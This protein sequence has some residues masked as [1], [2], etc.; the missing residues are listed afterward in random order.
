MPT[1]DELVSLTSVFGS[2]NSIEEQELRTKK[3]PE[4]EDT[5]AEKTPAADSAA[6]TELPANAAVQRTPSTAEPLPLPTI[7]EEDSLFNIYAIPL[8]YPAAYALVKPYVRGFDMNG[9]D[10]PS[11]KDVT[12]DN[13]WQLKGQS[14]ESN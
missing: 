6:K 7:S 8:Y 1:T 5:N 2:L 10:A 11:L 12:I 14:P 13:S 4:T 3:G 9:L